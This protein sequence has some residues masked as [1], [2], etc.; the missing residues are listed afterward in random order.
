MAVPEQA[1]YQKGTQGNW[2]AKIGEAINKRKLNNASNT[3]GKDN[4]GDGISFEA[5]SNEGFDSFGHGTKKKGTGIFATIDKIMTGGKK[6]VDENMSN[7]DTS[8]QNKGITTYKN[9]EIVDKNNTS[10]E[11]VSQSGAKFNV[12]KVMTPLLASLHQGMTDDKGVFQGG[13][14]GR[15]FGRLKD[16]FGKFKN[17]TDARNQANKNN[18]D[19]SGETPSDG[20]MPKF[21]V[22]NNEEV[23]TAQNMLIQLGYMS[24]D[25][26]QGEG[27]DGMFGKNTEAAWRAYTNDQRTF[28][29]KE[30]YTYEDN[31]AVVAEQKKDSFGYGTNYEGTS[32][33]TN[34][35]LPGDKN[36]V[37]ENTNDSSLGMNLGQG[38]TPVPISQDGSEGTLGNMDYG[39]S[40]EWVN[41]DG[42][43]KMYDWNDSNGPF[44]MGTR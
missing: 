9:G 36:G 31:N 44:K 26:E 38:Q 37:V 41:K 3:E 23:A 27:A 14:E 16:M 21:D 33:E 1:Q 22:N 18:I 10:N 32:F 4:A 25:Q 2:G 8:S 13:K 11:F 34:E 24:G 29:G 40:Y 12:P 20:N 28:N 35:V 42:S 5:N 30:A 39:N 15:V 43:V 19:Y 6:Y 7:V 17:T